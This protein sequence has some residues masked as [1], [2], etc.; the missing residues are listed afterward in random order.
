MPGDRFPHLSTK[1]PPNRGPTPVKVRLVWVMALRVGLISILLGA[2]LIFDYRSGN[3]FADPSSRFLLTLIGITYFLTIVYALWYRS[4]DRIVLLSRVQLTVDLLFWGCL[5][6]ATGGI[7]SGFTFLFDL[8]IIVAAIVLGGRAAFHSAAASVVILV[9]LVGA[10]ATGLLQPLAGHGDGGATAREYAYFLS[11]NIIALFVVAILVNSLVARLERTDRGLAVERVKRADLAQLN[12]DM[13]RSLTVGIA[14]T[15]LNGDV[16]M[17]NPAGLS[18]LGIENNPVEGQQLSTWVPEFA[19]EAVIVSGYRIRGQYTGMKQDSTRI[20]LEC[21][22]APLLGANGLRKGAI[23]VF[24]DLSEVRRLEAEVERA[25]RLA[26]LGELAASLAHEIRNPLGAVSGSFQILASAVSNQSEDR[27]LINIISRELRR[28]E[29]LVA[30]MLDYARP[31]SGR[32]ATTDI[33]KLVGEV[34]QVFL[35]GQD[36]VGTNI[37]VSAD[38]TKPIE[39][40][41][42][43][44]QIRQVIWN[45]LRN[46]AQATEPGDHIEAS[47]DMIGERV[48]IEICDTGRGIAQEDLD[49]IFDPFFSKRER[50]IGLGLA[51]CKR[52]VEAHDGHI[53]ASRRQGKGSIFRITLPLGKSDGV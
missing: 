27:E 31:R 17:M 46:A 10:M 6:Y 39:A 53:E 47:V 16:V 12:A 8:W 50:G 29:Q 18:I 32:R 14:T 25:R 9:L 20:P 3:A 49:K 1:P 5:T 30:D 4:G 34:A 40:I 22:V 33:N 48:V 44:S 28:M 26:A 41:V 45:L 19:S 43:P 13:I 2:T 38:E 11:V 36:Q 24:S 51:L 23:V 35:M 15:D 52:I 37:K 21:I 42:D 7:I